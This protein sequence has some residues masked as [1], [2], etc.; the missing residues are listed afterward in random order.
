MRYIPGSDRGPLL[1]HR[2]LNDDPRIHAFEVRADS[3]DESLAVSMPLTAG[4]CI[5]HDGRTV[6][7]ALP[8]LSA[9]DR[10]AY[11][12]VFSPPPVL[13]RRERAVTLGSSDTA[14]MR[15]RARWLRRGGFLIYAI[16]RLRQGLRSSPGALWLKA[17]LLMRVVGVRAVTGR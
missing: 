14:N 6:H 10:F 12:V 2:W 17:R 16:R 11:V 5:A 1:P 3:F 13:A 8:N 7:S 9:E 4:S 15:R